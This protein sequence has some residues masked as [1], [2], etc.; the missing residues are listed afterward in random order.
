MTLQQQVPPVPTVPGMWNVSLSSSG[1]ARRI[2]LPKGAL[3]RPG[4]DTPDFAHILESGIVST[5]LS[6]GK[7]RTMAVRILAPGDLLEMDQ[8]LGCSHRQVI[9]KVLVPGVALRIPFQNL[10]SAL[11]QDHFLQHNVFR[12]LGT[13][14][15]ELEQLS[16]CAS[17]HSLEQRLAKHLLLLSRVGPMSCIPITQEEL[18]QHLGVQRSSIVGSAGA[19]RD[20]G[21]IAF[22]RGNIAIPDRARLEEAAC[23]C[24]G[25]LRELHRHVP[26]N[27]DTYPLQ[28]CVA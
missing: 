7:G 15:I 16:A 11:N 24:Y 18:A 19:L 25:I 5:F 17:F 1:S 14:A 3:L 21:L 8:L 13:R 22:R 27:Y 28:Q 10:Q 6:F 4:A 12:A 26:P 9:H 23:E 20:R 2:C